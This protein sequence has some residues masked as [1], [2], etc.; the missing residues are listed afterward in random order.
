LGKSFKTVGGGIFLTHIVYTVLVDTLNHAQSPPVKMALTV[1][2]SGLLGPPGAT[3]S[4]VACDL[5][6]Y[7]FRRCILGL[8]CYICY[9]KQAGIVCRL[10]WI[11]CCRHRHFDMSPFWPGTDCVHKYTVVHAHNTWTRQ[12]S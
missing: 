5:H 7:N 11:R 4:L 1:C 10:F 9:Y 2:L 3:F 6:F 12:H 8:L